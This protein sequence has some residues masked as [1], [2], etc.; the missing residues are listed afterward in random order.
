MRIDLP[1]EH[2]DNPVAHL[3][4]TFA[5]EIV[6]AGLAF[7]TAVYQH[8][9]LTLREFEG[10]RART[11]EIN[12]CRVCQNFRTARDLPAYF[13][14]FGGPDPRFRRGARTRAG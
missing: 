13:E 12:G 8:S 5:P 11:A 4:H 2:L 14:A 7:S 6:Q 9:T 3:A 10:A 1:I